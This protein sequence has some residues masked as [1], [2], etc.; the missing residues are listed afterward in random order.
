MER[1]EKRGP[2]RPRKENPK[3]DLKL[4]GLRVQPH[5]EMVV[6][7]IAD[8]LGGEASIKSSAEQLLDSAACWV[9]EGEK[10]SLASISKEEKFAIIGVVNSWWIEPLSHITPDTLAWE[11]EEYLAP[12]GE[13]FLFGWQEEK[14]KDLVDTLA[15]LAPSE[16]IALLLWAKRFWNQDTLSVE[17]YIEST[18]PQ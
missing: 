6:E 4:L 2:G 8:S 5:T 18:T 16:T 14:K 15:S 13:G 9:E 17:E 3:T 1:P 12:G 7:K 11:I 10:S